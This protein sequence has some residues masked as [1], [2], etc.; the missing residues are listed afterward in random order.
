[1]DPDKPFIIAI[2]GYSSCG[3]STLARDLADELSFVYVD[4]GAMYRAV[5]LYL[6][7]EKTDWR[8][9]AT[10]QRA[11]DQIDIRFV[12]QEQRQITLLNGTEVEKEIRSMEVSS[13]VSEISTLSP[14]RRKLVDLQR[15]LGQS[16]SIVMDGRDI[17]TV[18]FPQADLKIFLTA[19]EEVRISRRYHELREK[20]EHIPASAVRENLLHRDLIDSTRADS[21]LMQADDAVV[22]DNSS[23]SR[24]EQVAIALDWVRERVRPGQG[25]C[26]PM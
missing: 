15:Q 16:R 25:R 19:S 8:D 9:P 23:L 7:R 14:V 12:Q 2:D 20:G 5:T 1:M 3:K 6:L 26:S 21:P 10:L 4:S 11:L 17:G 18:V 13:M 24:E 22:L